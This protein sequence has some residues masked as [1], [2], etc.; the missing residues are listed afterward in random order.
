M[1]N[2]GS[3]DTGKT[4]IGNGN[5]KSPIYEEIGTNSGLT[6]SSVV[7]AQGNNAFNVASPAA[8]GTILMS[9]GPFVDPSFQS[10][11]SFVGNTIT[12][13]TGGALP[14]TAGNWNILGQQANTN[15]V[16][17]TMCSGS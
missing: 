4:L 13:D 10:G 7:L 2:V 16:M 3:G 12:G 5:G 15:P 17:D 6:A 9:N 8:A 1:A 14:P 11:G